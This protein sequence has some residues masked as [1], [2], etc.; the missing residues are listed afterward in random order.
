MTTDL[1]VWYHSIQD[2]LKKAIQRISNVSYECN[3]L[4]KLK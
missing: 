4:L 3:S 1:A 2:Y